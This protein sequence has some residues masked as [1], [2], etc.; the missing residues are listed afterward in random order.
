MAPGLELTLIE[1][2][3]T[4]TCTGFAMCGS[5]VSPG[6][7]GPYGADAA[8]LGTLSAPRPGTADGLDVR[9]P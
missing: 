1:P 8:T 7:G 9:D 6:V 5:V 4:I 3:Q 2:S